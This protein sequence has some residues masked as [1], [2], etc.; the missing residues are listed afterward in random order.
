MCDVGMFKKLVQVKT[1]EPV[2]AVRAFSVDKDALT[3]FYDP[4]F[5]YKPGANVA[6][7]EVDNLGDAGFWACKRYDECRMEFDATIIGKVELYGK[8]AKHSNGYRA[9]KLRI[10][11]LY[12][13]GPHVAELA[14]AYKVP[15]LKV[16]AKRKRATTGAAA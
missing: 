4:R 12:D 8:V 16:P 15:V 6:V 9:E 1:S 2:V 5:K 3:A 7:G 10:V 11:G 14:K 13:T